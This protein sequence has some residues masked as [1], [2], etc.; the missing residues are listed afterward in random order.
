MR[1]SLASRLML[2][3]GVLVAAGAVIL[4]TAAWYYA[5]AAADD[6]YD[7]L[8]V[9]AVLQMTES[10]AVEEGELTV[11][12]PVSAFELLGLAGQ[13]RIFYRVI[14]TAGRTLTGYDD[15]AVPPGAAGVMGDQP[16]V[17][18]GRHGGEAVRMAVA[19]RRLTDPAIN[20]TARVVV[21]QTERARRDLAR[22]LTLRVVGLVVV[23]AAVAVA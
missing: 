15:L 7:R 14:D 23:M 2:R 20:G 13:D 5:R 22:E 19:A 21:A 6:A 8:L 10:L 9:G 12:L 11:S 1:P 4:V 16:L 3:I 18:G 17:T